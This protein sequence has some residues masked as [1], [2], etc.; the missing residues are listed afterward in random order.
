MTKLRIM[1]VGIFALLVWSGC[2]C[3]ETINY[4]YDNLSRLDQVIYDNGQQTITY[5]YDDAGNLLT[6]SN[7][8][9]IMVDAFEDGINSATAV[10]VNAVSLGVFYVTGQNVNDFSNAVSDGAQQ[11]SDRAWNTI[12]GWFD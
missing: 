12:E 10:T 5:N 1:A 9:W 3:A 2:L 11:V 7:D 4:I 6:K 8:L